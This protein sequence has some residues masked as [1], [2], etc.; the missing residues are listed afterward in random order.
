VPG[1]VS[2]PAPSPGPPD[3]ASPRVEHDGRSPRTLPVGRRAIS[4]G[5][6]TVTA[7][8]DTDSNIAATFRD[9][10]ALGTLSNYGVGEDGTIVGR[11]ATG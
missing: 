6:D 8:A 10:F 7:L 4:S 5:Q 3:P 9:G 1:L 2:S 11:S